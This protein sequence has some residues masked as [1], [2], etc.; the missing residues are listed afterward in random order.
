MLHLA[1]Q[2]WSVPV[3]HRPNSNWFRTRR[4]F[5]QAG[6]TPQIIQAETHPFEESECQLHQRN[7]TKLTRLAL[8][9][10][11]QNE[12]PFPPVLVGL[13]VFICWIPMANLVLADDLL[14]AEQLTAGWEESRIRAVKDA[15]RDVSANPENQ[16]YNVLTLERHLVS[17]E[18]IQAGEIVPDNTLHERPKRT[19]CLVRKVRDT[20]WIRYNREFRP[21]LGLASRDQYEWIVDNKGILQIS[22]QH[23]LPSEGSTAAI[24][25]V[26]HEGYLSEQLSMLQRDYLLPNLLN[27]V[28]FS[29]QRK[30]VRYR[31]DSNKVPR[32]EIDFPLQPIRPGDADELPKTAGGD[33]RV[34]L[35]AQ[36]PHL[37]VFKR[38]YRPYSESSPFPDN[39]GISY[40][41]ERSPS[42]PVFLNR[43]VYQPLTSELPKQISR[44][45]RF[46]R[47]AFDSQEIPLI[48][49]TETGH[50]WRI[51]NEKKWITIP[52]EAVPQ[53]FLDRVELVSKEEARKCFEEFPEQFVAV[54]ER[55]QNLPVP[56]FD[57][58]IA[59]KHDVAESL[60]QRLASS[61][62]NAEDSRDFRSIFLALG[63]TLILLAIMLFVAFG[64]SRLV[65]ARQP[66]N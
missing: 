65:S 26:G 21:T 38:R 20:I 46:E 60:P 19:C 66:T 41:Y 22:R 40:F 16:N 58:V 59:M 63:T 54:R 15:I 39:V 47:V 52:E 64:T 61:Q 27:S 7:S 62:L 57:E 49:I 14:T 10:L 2:D 32:L 8:K 34:L 48:R 24:Y 18:T 1:L 11:L 13:A 44:E 51:R 55:L 3:T 43:V 45:A 53:Q 30:D 9:H 5:V 4:R 31:V 17:G 33:S 25:Q 36:K 56:S 42:K 29:L 37:P 35:S 6:D 50:C 28:V 23:G 12:V